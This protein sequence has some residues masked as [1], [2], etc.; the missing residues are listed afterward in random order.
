MLT[1]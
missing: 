1:H